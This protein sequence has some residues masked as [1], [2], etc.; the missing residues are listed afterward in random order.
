MSEPQDKQYYEEQ[1]NSA[2]ETQDKAYSSQKEGQPYPD[3]LFSKGFDAYGQYPLTFANSEQNKKILTNIESAV[4]AIVI[5]TGEIAS[6][7]SLADGYI[8]S[9]DYV[10]GS[11]GWRISATGTVDFVGGNFR[12]DITGASG[13][14]T[15][16][17][18]GNTIIGANIQGTT[19]IGATIKTSNLVGIG[20][21]GVVLDPYGIRGYHYQVGKVFDIPTDGSF[22]TFSSGI[23]EQTEFFSSTIS[24]GVINGAVITGGLLRTGFEGRRVEIN[25]LGIQAISGAQGSFYGDEAQLYGDTDRPYGSGVL[26]YF[27]NSSKKVPLYVNMEQNVADIHLYNRTAVPSSTS[28]LGDLAMINNYLY[29][30]T[31]AGTPGT[32]TQI[33]NTGNKDT[34]T[35]LGTSDDK[36]PTQNAVKSY[37][38]N[39]KSESLTYSDTLNTA[40]YF[41]GTLG[42]EL[43]GIKTISSASSNGVT[44][45]G[46]NRLIVTQAGKYTVSAQQLTQ[47]SGTQYLRIQKNGTTVVQSYTNNTTNYV[48][49]AASCIVDMAVDDYIEI[50]LQNTSTNV[51]S[52]IHSQISMFKIGT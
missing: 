16:T 1:M 11:S 43:T 31:S 13:T 22:P 24:G 48:D 33:E 9:D 27:N 39:A 49:L 23:I 45:S 8:Q 37:A 35:S 14:F 34:N 25:D 15:G 6:N 20:S 47:N 40:I 10:A 7:L 17:L 3:S 26:V 36:Y 12:G 21:S 38:D 51:W 52:G 41:S 44:L 46:G 18:S 32:W 5:Q 4:P 42:G 50:S 30:C 19:I 2:R 28:E 29:F